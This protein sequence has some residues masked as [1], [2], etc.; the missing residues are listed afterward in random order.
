MTP[1]A[2]SP[3]IPATEA[4]RSWLRRHRRAIVLGTVLPIVVLLAAG[5]AASWHFSSAVVVP[6]HSPSPRNATVET[7][8]SNAV[9]LTRSAQ[10]LRAGVYG[11][12]WPGGHA[13]VEGVLDRNADTVTRRLRAVR[14]Q[15]TL[16]TRV[17]VDSTTFEGNPRQA[18]GLPFANVEVPDELGPMP[19]WLV[20]G[21]SRTWAIFVH[22]INADREDGL[23]IVPPLHAS[24]LP[25][26]LITYRDD[27][28]A[29]A[30]PDGKHHMGLTEWRDLQAAARYA[31]AHG[32]HHL[33]L[34][35]YSMGG[36]I[37][38]QFMERSPLASR[39]AALI[40]DAPA[41]N[42]KTVLSFNAS[43][44]GLP[45]FAA[46]PVEWLI[47][48]RIDAD[49][50]S[51]DALRHTA[52]FHLPILLFHGTDDTLVP[53]S[54]SDAFAKALRGWV[55]YYRVPGAEHVESWNA[56]PQLYDRR[57]TAFLRKIPAAIRSANARLLALARIQSAADRDDRCA[58]GLSVAN[59][60]QG[61]S[62]CGRGRPGLRPRLAFE[63][64]CEILDA[65]L[66]GGDLEHGA[67][68]HAVHVA[69]ERVGLDPE[70]QQPAGRDSPLGTPHFALETHVIGLGGC[71]RGEIVCP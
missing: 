67:D 17:A 30:S 21:Q 66:S 49:W 45:S 28:G 58:A 48:L 57:V 68:E 6:D 35:G 70:L 16:G 23:R 19:A 47:G 9:V 64:L 54:T 71:E 34:V 31:L 20:P 52:D 1:D 60:C 25:T 10:T 46:D 42:W 59:R 13:I 14:G 36:A 8:T 53:I 7:L 27:V 5:A 2:P 22:G 63:Q 29:P 41:L 38:A 51:L 37:V 4:T 40:L 43:E 18:L 50:D 44:M 55:T 56:D 62:V 33:V 24:G 65:A 61:Q 32:A 11:L 69:H 3:A 39:V 15:L 26:L 12:K